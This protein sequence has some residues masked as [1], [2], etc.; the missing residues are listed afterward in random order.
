MSELE[1]VIRNIADAL[2]SDVLPV[3]AFVFIVVSV[4]W[5]VT[6]YTKE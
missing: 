6:N 5:L 2:L 1:Y 3:L 4:R